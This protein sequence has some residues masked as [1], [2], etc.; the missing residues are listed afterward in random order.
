VI[1]TLPNLLFMKYTTTRV[2][3]ALLIALPICFSACVKDDC[4]QKYSYTYYIPVYITKTEARADVKSNR[5]RKLE[6][7]G[8]IYIRDKYIF[9]NEVDR[10]IHIIDNSNPKIPRNVAFISIPGNQDIAVKGNILYADMYSDLLTIDISNP[11]QVELKNYLENVFPFRG[12]GLGGYGPGSNRIVAD[13]IRKD[14]TITGSCEEPI[15]DFQ[16]I[17]GG[18]L[19]FL[20]SSSSPLTSVSPIGRGGSMARFT[21]VNDRMYSVSTS[22][23]DVFNVSTPENPVKGAKINLGWNI[24]TIYPFGNKLFIGSQSGMF[25]Y[26]ISNPDAPQA[27]GQFTHARSCDPVIADND[28]AYVTLRSGTACQGFS[29]QLEVVRLNNLLNPTLV[30]TYPMVNPHGLSKDGDLLF[31]CDG[32]SGV[33]VYDATD[34]E[35]LKLVKHIDDFDAYDVITFN[36]VALIIG[37]NGLY[38]YSYTNPTNIKQ[39]SKIQVEK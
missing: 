11:L 17:Y 8:K 5:P 14:T 12:F 26:D 18:G 36:Q 4:K 35:N 30:K 29:N 7:P 25:I 33:K 1:V 22:S 23:L 24:E 21:L 38:Q 20:A 10:G 2:I 15:F 9:L 3:A 28:Y 31:I 37:K 16:N 34:N 6:N 39:L 13:W 27:A 19:W 32:S